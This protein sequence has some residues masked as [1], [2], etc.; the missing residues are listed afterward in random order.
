MLTEQC[1]HQQPTCSV[2]EKA[3]EDCTYPSETCRNM[4]SICIYR[5][6]SSHGEDLELDMSRFVEHRLEELESALNFVL[7]K[8]GVRKVF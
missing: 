1:H 5:R 8:E 4:F 3:R 7:T 6:P 2:C